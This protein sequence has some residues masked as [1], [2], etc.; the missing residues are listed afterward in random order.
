MEEAFRAVVGEK[1]R[2]QMRGMLVPLKSDE[3]SRFPKV[4]NRNS[5]IGDTRKYVP[6][7]G[8]RVKTGRHGKFEELE[9][10][11]GGGM[12]PLYHGTN[13]YRV[14]SILL[15]SL[16]LSP[17]DGAMFG[18]A[19]YLTPDIGKSMT[20]GEWV[21]V[22]KA[23]LGRVRVMEDSDSSLNADKAWEGGF[24]T[25]H[26]VSGKTAAWAGTLRY[27]EYAVYDPNR[28]LITHVLKYRPWEE[29]P[30]WLNPERRRNPY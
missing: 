25:V 23:C 19:V 6:A 30:P 9:R 24:D 16:R 20:Y 29:K 18:K 15:R 8:W 14:V 17:V 1:Y 2:D 7:F 5:W 27:S 12:F 4:E 10:M 3:V 11:E 21:V 22:A 28:V 26:G 13:S